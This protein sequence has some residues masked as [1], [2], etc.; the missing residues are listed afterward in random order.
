MEGIE[1]DASN[2]CAARGRGENLGL[3][4]ASAWWGHA[5]LPHWAESSTRYLGVAFSS[6]HSAKGS[7]YLGRSWC[8]QEGT[9]PPAS[10]TPRHAHL[11]FSADPGLGPSLSAELA[12]VS[13][14]SLQSCP[15]PS[16]RPSLHLVWPGVL[17]LPASMAG[18]S[19][20]GVGQ[21]P[22]GCLVPV[23][24]CGLRLQKAPLFDWR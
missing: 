15:G 20:P 16:G 14:T 1:A 4:G 11:I 6:L 22:R 13:P 17:T 24:R 3:K 18:K 2:S 19:G 7:W 5:R 12:G 9:S 23:C 8:P 10:H 21:H